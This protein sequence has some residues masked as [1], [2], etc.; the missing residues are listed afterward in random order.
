MTGTATKPTDSAEAKRSAPGVYVVVY[1]HNGTESVEL[2]SDNQAAA[3]VGALTYGSKQHRQELEKD[4]QDL[5]EGGGSHEIN[6]RDIK[7]YRLSTT[8]VTDF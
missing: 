1:E 8:E 7:V 4:D 3:R 2:L 6:R 5:P